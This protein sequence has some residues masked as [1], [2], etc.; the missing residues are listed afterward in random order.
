MKRIAFLLMAVC[1]LF[2][3]TALAQSSE[4]AAR[5]NQLYDDLSAHAG[6]VA[7]SC[8][9][10]GSS[11]SGGHRGFVMQRGAGTGWTTGRRITL[12]NIKAGKAAR[13]RKVFASCKKIG[14]S[15]LRN[16]G[17]A[18]VFDEYTHLLWL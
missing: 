10:T 6:A 12:K 16:A 14:F 4:D 17:W 13:I 7:D 18:N 8:R 11:F 15:N 5:L 9:Y 2:A 3:H 1:S